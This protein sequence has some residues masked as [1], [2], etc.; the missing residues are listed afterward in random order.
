[1]SV[2]D[3][4]TEYF[5]TANGI[6]TTFAY[7]FYLLQL[8]DIRV[9]L[10]GVVQ[11]TGFTVNGVGSQ[12][13]GAV[14]FSV[15][16]AD[17]V[18]VLIEREVAIKRDSDFQPNGDLRADVLNNEL[19]RLWMVLQ[20]R[21][22]ENV[23]SLRY[24]NAE[25]LD[26][27]LP[28]AAT[29]AN[30][31]LGFSSTGLHAMIP[32]P[33]SIG[34][35]DIVPQTFTAGV[36]FTAGVTTELTLAR[37]PGSAGN[38]EVFFDGVFQ[39]FDQWGVAGTTLSF[40]NPIPVGVLK[41]F[42]RIGTTLSI[43]TPPDSSVGDLQIAWGS[44]LDRKVDSVVALRALDGN[45]FSSAAT[46]GYYSPRDGGH[47]EFDKDASD[48]SSADNNGTIIVGTDGTR[49]K[50]RPRAEVSAAC[51][52]VIPGVANVGARLNQALAD[53]RGKYRLLLP[54]GDILT[55]TTQVVVPGGCDVLGTGPVNTSYGNDM[56]QSAH[57]TKI[58]SAVVN[59]WAVELN[60]PNVFFA[61][62]THFGQIEITNPAG[63]GLYVEGIGAGARLHNIVVRNCP[64]E[65]YKF[66]YYQDSVLDAIECVNC[67]TDVKH[68][69]TFENNCNAVQV[70]KLLI[71]Q[72]R[73]P[74]KVD[75][76]TYMDFYSSHI[77]EGEYPPGHA[78]EYL[79]VAYIAGGFAVNNSSDVTFFGG[80]FVPNSYPFLASFYSIA[81]SATPFYFTTTNSRRT[82]FIGSK[83]STPRLGARFVSA[84]EAEFIDNTF[85]GASTLV[86]SIEGTA[87]TI[88]GGE[89][90]LYDDQV[91][92]NF[93]CINL[94]GLSEVRD[95]KLRCSNPASATKTTG[96]LINGTGSYLGNYRIEVD[97]SNI[98][99]GGGLI[100]K[101]AQG[102]G[103][104]GYNL[105]GGV[106]D[107]TKQNAGDA[108]VVNSVGSSLLSLTGIHGNGTKY[109]VV[110]NTAGNLTVGTGG[111]IST[112][113][114]ITVPAFG[115]ID[116]KHIPGTAVLSPV[117]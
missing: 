80:V 51:F 117:V 89:I 41:V 19:D 44:I 26:G 10:N 110:N 11:T 66:F 62:G 8:A 18:S 13:G 16:P 84:Q 75:G 71:V 115:S 111:N 29:R 61:P 47:A 103:G 76:C 63:K 31:L 69:V 28:N 78:L 4:Q 14:V 74:L 95:V 65:G 114:T 52:G 94:A 58:V 53:H 1:M 93:D 73:Q 7:G 39:G 33:A 113:S 2:P 50:M 83:W 9:S 86:N 25:N 56:V 112:P 49:W 43:T 37:A 42:V 67:G 87:I 102:A 98:H 3:Q 15:A 90:E 23:R 5:Y 107:V 88:H 32:L 91:Q 77:E 116:I 81:N 96:T 99:V 27:V 45:R 92:T 12:T 64:Q 17:G 85:N 22:S 70:H 30:M 55:G 101:G 38:L 54:Q 59:D 106:I 104:T 20:D 21:R 36:D 40:S 60:S 109:T 46:R 105:T 68:A 24:P 6:T 108:V 72:C 57:G 48:T 35:G 97:K 100:Y 34:A 79:N 82:R